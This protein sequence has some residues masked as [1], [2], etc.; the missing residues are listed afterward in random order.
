M[1]VCVVCRQP[2]YRR[3]MSEVWV[4]HEGRK[5][6]KWRKTIVRG[7]PDCLRILSRATLLF[8]RSA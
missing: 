1:K 2:Y 4:R 8:R 5:D 3:N 7:H 6:S